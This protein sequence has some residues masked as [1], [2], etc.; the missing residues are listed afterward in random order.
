M[1]PTMRTSSPLMLWMPKSITVRFPVS[2][3]SS[4]IFLVT[5]FTTSSMR[6]G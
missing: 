5:L 4:S 2:A 6:A 1:R 3:I